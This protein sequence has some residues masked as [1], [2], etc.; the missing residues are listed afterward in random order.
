MAAL[1]T[2]T[3]PRA[4]PLPRA[5]ASPGWAGDWARRG[6][7][8]SRSRTA[9]PPGRGHFLPGEFCVHDSNPQAVS[10]ARQLWGAG[11]RGAAALR[12]P[13]P[14]P[15]AGRWGGAPGKGPRARGAGGRAG[16]G[17]RGRGGRGSTSR[18]E[19]RRSCS[20]T[21]C[22]I[23]FTV[24]QE[25]KSGYLLE[26]LF[27]IVRRHT[28]GASLCAG[29]PLFPERNNNLKLSLKSSLSIINSIF[30]SLSPAARVSGRVC[31]RRASGGRVCSEC[32]SGA[33][34]CA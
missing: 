7:P 13:D 15:G 14:S 29:N 2:D 32:A 16:V 20:R 21:N 26:Y 24:E 27:G 10:S 12:S 18:S 1:G 28:K 23:L 17:G 5:R 19:R 30:L 33:R 34:V 11:A 25:Q 4:P 22:S 6:P 31:A 8:A 3:W 9:R